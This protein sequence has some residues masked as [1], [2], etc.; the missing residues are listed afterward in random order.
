MISSLSAACC[1]CVQNSSSKSMNLPVTLVSSEASVI[2]SVST[3]SLSKAFS[4][5]SQSDLRRVG[6]RTLIFSKQDFWNAVWINKLS[7]SSSIREPLMSKNQRGGSLAY[8]DND[9]S[10][11]E[12]GPSPPIPYLRVRQ[13]PLLQKELR[14][15]SLHL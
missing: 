15:A 7:V 14:G 5:C 13:R 1:M 10:W 8:L 12:S 6:G 3:I 2:C 9:E 11:G 4:N